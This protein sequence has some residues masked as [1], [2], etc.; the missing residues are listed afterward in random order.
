MR[1]LVT[2]H[3]GYIGAVLVPVFQELGHD[4]VGLDTSL[5]RANAI[6]PLEDVPNIAKDVRDVEYRDLVGFDAIVHLAGLSNDPLGNL[7]P[8]LT[9]AINYHAS[10]RLAELAKTAGV[11]RFLFAS[12]CSVYGVEGGMADESSPLHPLTPYAKSKTLVEQ[13]LA[14]VAGENF[15]PV[16]L[17]CATAYGLS[18]VPR[19]D[20][21]LNNFVAHAE[22]T[23]HVLLKSAGTSWRPLTHIRDII[24]AYAVLLEAPKELI[25]N[26]AFNVGRTE[27]NIRIRD[28]ADT[29]A[30]VVPGAK[31]TI[32]EG[33]EPDK[34]SY[35]VSCDALSETVPA[36]RPSWTPK[37][38]AEEM[39]EAFSRGLFAGRDIEGPSFVRLKQLDAHRRAGRLAPDLRPVAPLS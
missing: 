34:R 18:P 30:R 21:V 33:A 3:E 9:Y 31:V 38:G 1:I 12:S 25:S 19:F 20:V 10:V 27:D 22:T 4:I 7:D 11:P 23:G 36:Y 2:G 39:H 37:K 35:R 29:V 32:A 26:R 17:R 24:H 6:A 13:E 28:L 16:Y 14:H 8:E 15:C 5:F